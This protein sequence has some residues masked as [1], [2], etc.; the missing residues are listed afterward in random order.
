M[1]QSL[2]SDEERRGA[3]RRHL[4]HIAKVQTGPGNE[5]RAC[6]VLDISD[7]GVRL[8]IILGSEVPSEFDLVLS[9]SIVE[10]C[11][12]IWRRHHELGATFIS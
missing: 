2:K 10:R 1:M 4:Y 11:K 3:L 12:V 7:T 8:D 5:P 6:R 9:D